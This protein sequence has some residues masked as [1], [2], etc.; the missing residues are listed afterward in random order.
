MDVERELLFC[1]ELGLEIA[2]VI[3]NMSGFKCL[4]CGDCTNVFSRGGGSALARKYGIRFLGELPI[5]PQVAEMFEREDGNVVAE[6]KDSELCPLIS[7]IMDKLL[8][9]RGEHRR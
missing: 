7:Q 1:K 3:E 6:Y 5:V 2:G 4:E 9:I 8:I